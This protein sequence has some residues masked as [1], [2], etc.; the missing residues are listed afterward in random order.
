MLGSQRPSKSRVRPPSKQRIRGA[1]RAVIRMYGTDAL[2]KAAE[3][4]RVFNSQGYH[5]LAAGW[6]FIEEEIQHLQG[7]NY[8]IKAR[9]SP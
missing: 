5:S 7:K 8:P 1:G 4:V 2:A 3:H 9:R 6:K